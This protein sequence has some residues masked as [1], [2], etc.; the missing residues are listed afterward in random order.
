MR[1]SSEAFSKAITFVEFERS[2]NPQEKY[3]AGGGVLSDFLKEATATGT[4][5]PYIEQVLVETEERFAEMEYAINRYF[6][7]TF[8]VSMEHRDPEAYRAMR[9]LEALEEDY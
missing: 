7:A 1:H 8:T 6:T 9:L 4:Y 3:R 5:V 2:G